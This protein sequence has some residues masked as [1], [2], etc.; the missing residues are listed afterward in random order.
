MAAKKNCD[1][2]EHIRLLFIQSPNRQR[3]VLYLRF[4]SS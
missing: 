3:V 1:K 2:H 4:E